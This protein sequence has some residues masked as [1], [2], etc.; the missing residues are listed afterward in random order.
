MSYLIVRCPRCGEPR[1]VKKGRRE[2]TC[3][4][5]NAMRPL[6]QARVLGEVARLGDA[7]HAV[8]E[9]K[10]ARGLEGRAQA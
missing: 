10:R 5:C 4:R 7:I 8:K 9:L 1:Y 3:F 6:S 2:F